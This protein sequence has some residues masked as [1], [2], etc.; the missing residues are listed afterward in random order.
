MKARRQKKGFTLVEVMLAVSLSVMVFAAMGMVLTKCFSLWK[1][2]TAQWR[3]AQYSRIARE[4]IL[5]GG[6]VDPAGGLLAA[7]NATSTTDAGWGDLVYATVAGTGGVVR[8]RGWV[9]E[10]DGK[11]LLLRQG[12]SDWRYGLQSG[13]SVPE[14]KADFFTVVVSNDLV[15]VVYRLRLNA[16]GKTFVQPH[17]VRACLVNKE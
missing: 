14:I 8:V 13:S 4:R 10:S 15:T 1:D 17:T 11:D 2:A 3:L 16:G 6:F 12:V 9:G 7:T 5:C